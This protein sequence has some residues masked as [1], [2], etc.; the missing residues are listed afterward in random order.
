METLKFPK[1][2]EK[3]SKLRKTGVKT[4]KFHK[5]ETKT[6]K[7]SKKIKKWKDK[8]NKNWVAGRFLSSNKH[9][10]PSIE[11]SSTLLSIEII[12]VNLKILWLK[13]SE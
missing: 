10:A 8:K 11:N 3:L 7:L 6:T 4:L 13:R 5:N 2:G 1:N 12:V 9:C